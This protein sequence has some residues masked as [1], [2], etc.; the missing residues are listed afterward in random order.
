M[1][2]QTIQVS[3]LT[4]PDWVSIAQATGKSISSAY[5]NWAATTSID[6]A[7]LTIQDW[8]RIGQL[9]GFNPGWSYHR[10]REN[11]E[12][13]EQGTNQISPVNSSQ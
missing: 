6:L 9:C 1:F 2:E 12:A 5:Y 11:Q 8:E 7:S 10:Y 13:Q 4:L 3:E